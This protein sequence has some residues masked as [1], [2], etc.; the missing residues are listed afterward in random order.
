MRARHGQSGADPPGPEQGE[1]GDVLPADRLLGGHLVIAQ[2]Q[3]V[4]VPAVENARA[5]NLHLVGDVAPGR[6]GKC[7]D[8]SGGRRRRLFHADDIEDHLK[9]LTQLLHRG[10]DVA[11][12]HGRAV[13][14]Q[15]ENLLERVGLLQL[16]KRAGGL[17]H[18]RIAGG[19]ERGVAPLEVEG[20]LP[21]VRQLHGAHQHDRVGRMKLGVVVHV[22]KQ[23]S[24]RH[25]VM[26][27][28]THGLAI[29]D[30][31][32]LLTIEEHTGVP[33][34]ELR[35]VGERERLEPGIRLH[36]VARVE[37]GHA[38]ARTYA[39]G[40]AHMVGHR[41]AV[42]RAENPVVSRRL[43]AQ[44]C[45]QTCHF[46]AEIEERRCH[47]RAIL[48]GGLPRQRRRAREKVLLVAGIGS[49]GHREAIAIAMRKEVSVGEDRIL[50][51]RRVQRTVQIRAEA[52]AAIELGSPAGDLPTIV[53]GRR[54]AQP[55]G[56]LLRIGLAQQAQPGTHPLGGRALGVAAQVLL[57]LRLGLGHFPE[58]LPRET[59]HLL[60]LRTLGKLRLALQLRQDL[61]RLGIV[62]VLHLLACF[63]QESLDLTRWQRRVGPRRLDWR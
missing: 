34:R 60:H 13:P 29:T 7:L 39:P 48:Q 38:C 45:A 10:G 12:E 26:E 47:A 8:T 2:H 57:V 61:H 37:D 43:A 50:D 52:V 25:E 42:E 33:V 28:G 5:E 22:R 49:E 63:F 59:E 35:P 36:A 31:I 20:Q 62:V 21:A 9:T 14:R 6:P 11:R 30:A 53:R 4:E 19:Q 17:A 54:I 23:G 41:A 18:Q 40:R 15:P 3:L 58:S 1:A 32:E 56:A 51:D 24:R 44:A 46:V 16:R 55:P 27:L